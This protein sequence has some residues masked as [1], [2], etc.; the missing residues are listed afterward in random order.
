MVAKWKDIVTKEEETEEVEEGGRE[1]EGG[2]REVTNFTINWNYMYV[3]MK[4]GL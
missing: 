3:N 2:G 1:E 4:L